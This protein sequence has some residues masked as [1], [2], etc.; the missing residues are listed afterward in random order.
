M[1]KLLVLNKRV[2]SNNAF[3]KRSSIV[4]AV[5]TVAITTTGLYVV[6][7]MGELLL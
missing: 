6:L 3:R 4:I 2:D 7:T 1:G 5:V